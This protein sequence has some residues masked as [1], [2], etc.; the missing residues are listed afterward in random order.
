MS[1]TKIFFHKKDLDGH[2]SG[3]V[4]RYYFEKVAKQEVEMIPFDYGMELPEIGTEDLYFLDVT[5]SGYEILKELNRAN[6]LVVVDHHKTFIDFIKENK[7]NIAG[8]QTEGK[9]GCELTWEYF[10]TA[11]QTPRF[12]KLLSS[13]DIWDNKDTKKWDEEILPFQYGMRMENTSPKDKIATDKFYYWIEEHLSK[14]DNSARID[15]MIE[16]GNIIL[17]YQK[18]VD[19]KAVANFSFDVKFH[20]LKALCMNS[21]RFNSQ[22]F[23]SKWDPTKYDIMLNLVLTKGEYYTVSLYTTRTDIICGE[24]AKEFGGGGH[25]QAAGFIA[26]DFLI[27]DD[28]L[29]FKIT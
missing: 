8:Y 2:F 29:F 7:L 17:E 24:I 20:G 22:V 23:E 25:P 5:P 3:L 1:M 14:R 21:T 15:K 18:N 13:Y 6:H 11:I 12:L 26:K 28:T 19:K 4:A 16:R 27:K 10:F 9:A